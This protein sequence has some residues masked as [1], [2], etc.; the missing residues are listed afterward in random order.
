M[1]FLFANIVLHRLRLHRH[2]TF[3]FLWYEM[4]IIP[5]INFR[6]AGI[7][8][9]QLNFEK[10]LC[11]ART[12]MS[13]HAL[14]IARANCSISTMQIV[15]FATANILCSVTAQSDLY[16]SEIKMWN[17]FFESSLHTY[18]KIIKFLGLKTEATK[19][20]MGTHFSADV[21]WLLNGLAYN[22]YFT[23][24]KWGK[25]QIKSRKGG[26]SGMGMW[27][28]ERN[29]AYE[30]RRWKWKYRGEGREE[31]L[32]E[33]GWQSKGWYQREGTVGW[34]CVRLCYMEG[35]VIVHRPHIKVGIRWRRRRY[36]SQKTQHWYHRFMKSTQ[37]LNY[38]SG[39][40][41]QFTPNKGI[42]NL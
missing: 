4:P 42:S 22:I 27:R 39:K 16:G 11:S 15:C 19:Q 17:V 21:K 1:L 13:Q 37:S 28:E 18:K 6:E 3:T 25:S 40:L 23:E 24:Q 30:G 8:A 7:F 33:D 20:K 38:K 10:Q 2:W 9:C 41:L 36:I 29:T 32:R 35:Y 34:W 14:S 31:D 12:E 5:G 26:W